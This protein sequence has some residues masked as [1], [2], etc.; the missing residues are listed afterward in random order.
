MNGYRGNVEA[1]RNLMRETE[2]HRDVYIDEE[3]F[4]LEMEHLSSPTPG[5]MSA[6]T[7]R[8]QIPATISAP[9]S[10]RSRS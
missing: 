8:W 1:V 3:V 9:P 2:V 5:F 7:A 4:Q 6:M 10:A